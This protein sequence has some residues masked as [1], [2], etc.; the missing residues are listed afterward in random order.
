MYTKSWNSLSHPLSVRFQYPFGHMH[1]SS[2][3]ICSPGHIQ[4]FWS[5]IEF[6]GQ[7]QLSSTRI[8]PSHGQVQVLFLSN[9]SPGQIQPFSS[10]IE[11]PGQTQLS[12]RRICPSHGQVQVLSLSNWSPGQEQLPFK[13][14]CLPG[15]TQDLLTVIEKNVYI[16]TIR[17]KNT[18]IFFIKLVL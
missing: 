4:P 12:S 14:N 17:P 15:Q 10:R 5:R 11:F 13:N 2:F 6:P 8:C 16:D 7:T 3:S 1:S 9:W 18:P